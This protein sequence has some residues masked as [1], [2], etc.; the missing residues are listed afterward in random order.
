MLKTIKIL[1]SV[2]VIP[3]LKNVIVVLFIYLF[4]IIYF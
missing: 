3:L 4:I 1:I 2:Q